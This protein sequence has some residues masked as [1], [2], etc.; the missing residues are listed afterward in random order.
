MSIQDNPTPITAWEA[1]KE[2]VPASGAAF[3]KTTI[4]VSA[5]AAI[6]LPIILISHMADVPYTTSLKFVTGFRVLLLAPALFTGCVINVS[7][8]GTRS[9][10]YRTCH[11]LAALRH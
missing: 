4:A 11:A 7:I 3:D 2:S 9:L 8:L 10:A 1:F 6:I 5:A